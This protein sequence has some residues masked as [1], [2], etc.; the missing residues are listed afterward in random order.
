MGEIL[1]S[2]KKIIWETVVFVVLAI[3]LWSVMPY[4]FSSNNL[5]SKNQ[6][7]YSYK[8]L[9]VFD[10]S[11]FD[12]SIW[13]DNTEAGEVEQLISKIDKLS[14]KKTWK[15]MDSSSHRITVVGAYRGNDG[16]A[17]TEPVFS[18]TFYED[19]V[20]SFNEEPNYREKFYQVQDKEFDIKGVIEEIQKGKS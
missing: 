10:L 19:N 12:D 9:R 16:P 20:I 1:L 8:Q 18:I 7:D 13:I 3:I 5:I 14:L 11:G 2:K 4:I 17:Y 6:Y 15:P